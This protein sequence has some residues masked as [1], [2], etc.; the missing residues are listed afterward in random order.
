MKQSLLAAALVAIA[1]SA[2]SK[3]EEAAAVPAT[4]A[5]EVAAPAP[6]AAPVADQA[7]PADAGAPADA[8]KPA[9]LAVPAAG[10]AAA[11]PDKK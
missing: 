10:I 11:A 7:K 5:A 4:P 9:D 6:V 8:A 1:L 3:K 2:C